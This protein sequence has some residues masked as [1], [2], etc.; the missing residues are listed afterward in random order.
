MRLLHNYFTVPEFAKK[1][2]I[3]TTTVYRAIEDGRITVTYVGLSKIAFIAPSYL[4]IQ[5]RVNARKAP[6]D[7]F[8]PDLE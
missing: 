6:G 3:S 8:Q 7:E 4:K 1:K 2:S 5:F